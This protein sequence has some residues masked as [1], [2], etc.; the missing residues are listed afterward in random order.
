MWSEKVGGDKGTEEV[1]SLLLSMHIK[2]YS[3]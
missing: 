2:K 3:N 1:Y